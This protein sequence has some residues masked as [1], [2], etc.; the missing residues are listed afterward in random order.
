[1]MPMPDSLRLLHGSEAAPSELRPLRAGPVS[2]LLDGGDLRYVRIGRT[3]LLRRVYVAVR[4]S[5]WATVPAVV[6]N[7]RVDERDGA[8]SVAFAC[9]HTGPRLELTWDGTIS[10]DVDGRVEYVFDARAE[11]ES[12]YSRIGI[13]VHHPWRETAGAPFRATS[14]DGELEG[15]FPDLIG[16]QI[17]RDG[18]FHAIFAPFDRLEIDMRDGGSLRFEFEGELWEVEDHRNW[19]DANFK[20]YPMPLGRGRP[21]PLAAGQSL[22]QRVGV[23]PVGVAALEPEATPVRMRVGDALEAVMPPVG[24]AADRD[25]H[26]PDGREAEILAALAPRHLRVEV[27]FARHDWRAALTAGRE[28][29]ARIGAPLELALVLREEAL[30]AVEELA[31]ELEGGPSVERVIVLAA[32]ARPGVLGETTPPALVEG[33]RA[34]LAPSLEAVPF[35]GGTE[36]YFAELNRGTAPFDSWDGACFSITPQV[37]AFTDLDLVETLDSQ[38]EAVRSALAVTGGKP[39]VVSPITLLP[40]ENFYAAS[41]AAPETEPGALGWSVDPRQ[42]SLLGAAWTAGSLKYLAEAGAASVTYFECSGW[43]GVVERSA[44][45]PLPELFRSRPGMP[46]PLY[47]PLADA[48]EWEAARVM[49]CDSTDPLAAVA[50]A[51]RT[52]DGTLHLLVSN[53]TPRPLDVVLE[54]VDGTLELRRLDEASVLAEEADPAAGGR[55]HDL[56]E[57]HCSLPLALGP[58]EVVRID[59][60]R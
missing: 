47:H 17:F 39:V 12:A 13:C 14:P 58:Y 30:A 11:R 32:E 45:T 56:L 28:T 40:R 48:C 10:G 27:L 49:A 55:R 23:T 54:G 2:L 52:D 18:Y 15:A 7:L 35:V 21:A 26:R 24:L 59:E 41:R 51:V 6:S 44:G 25:G 34:A 16:R 3:E 60:R 33:V 29:A 42:A 4:D 9:R 5:D 8:F 20:T 19:T 36:M 53:L 1:M 31:E 50:L 38:G 46:F 57:G 22:L 43:C 37:H